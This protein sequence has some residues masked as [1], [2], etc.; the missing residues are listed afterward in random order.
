VYDKVAKPKTP[1]FEPARL[2]FG[3]IHILFAFAVMIGLLLAQ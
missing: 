3:I 2:W 1:A